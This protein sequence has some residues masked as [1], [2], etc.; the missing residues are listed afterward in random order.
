MTAPGAAGPRTGR[1]VVVG[2]S[3]AGLRA[4]EAL[5]DEGF[6]GELTMIGDEPHAPYDRPPLSKA[7]LSGRLDCDHIELPRVRDIDARW[8]LGTPATG[9]DVPGHRVALAD[10]RSMAYDRLL[11]ATGTRARTWPARAGG[12]LDGVHVLRTRE[13]AER[14]RGALLNGP[15]RVL[16]I[17]A[18]FTGGEVASSCAE[19]GLAVT[20]TQRGAAPLAGALGG[21]VGRAAADWYHAAGV[22]LRLNTTVRAL[23]GDPSGRLRRAVLS[24]G[25]VL[26]TEVAVVAT[27]ALANTEWLSGSG[28]AADHRGVVTDDRCRAMTT[29]GNPAEDIFATGDIAR[30]P[31]P[32]HPGRLLR[33]NH[34]DGAV[35]QART[36]AHHIV[37][38]PGAQ[39]LRQPLPAFW[40]QQ[41]G[42]YLK[43]IGVPAL[44]D[45]VAITQGSL[46]QRRFVAAYG[47]EG[48]LIGA[49]AVDS[50][51]VLDG[52]AALIEAR[53]PFPPA[54]GATDGPAHP[55]IIDAAFPGRDTGGTR[56][57][58]GHTPSAIAPAPNR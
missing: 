7:V 31:H 43:S 25:T 41:F 2:A 13:D 33:L 52:Y 40:S 38:G 6:T 22:D 49:V 53:A 39:H 10:G 16:V 51:R 11:I 14:L 23:E 45:Q 1:I 28:L 29:D 32:L 37:H 17:G 27:G 35:A 20:V 55:D 21:T 18:G 42:H 47:L 44:A 57:H 56:D 4:A 19:S 9:L 3:L 48:R 8:L 24:D 36:A 34:W 30:R 50:P 15:S 5:R 26:D 58:P 46:H 12:G 54:L